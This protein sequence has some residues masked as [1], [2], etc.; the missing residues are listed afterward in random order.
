MTEIRSETD[1]VFVLMHAGMQAQHM[2]SRGVCDRFSCYESSSDYFVF[3]GLQIVHSK[4]ARDL[5]T[6]S[7]IVT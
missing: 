7:R 5:F 4:S 6:A 2:L 1:S 3:T